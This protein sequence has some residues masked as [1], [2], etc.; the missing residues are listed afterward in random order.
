MFYAVSKI[1]WFLAQPSSLMELAL[2]YGLFRL[3]RSN[4]RHG[5]RW[6]TGGAAALLI[7]GLT[8]LGDLL[9]LPL[10]GRFARAD[11]AAGNIAGIIVLGGAE[12]SRSEGNRELMSLDDAGERMTEGAVLARQL[13][14]ARLVFSGGSDSLVRSKEPEAQAA[15]RLWLAL[16]VDPARLMIEDKSRSTAENATLSKALVQPKP[17]DRW[18]LVTSAWHM[19]RAVGSFRQAGFAVEPWPVDYRASERFHPLKVFSSL[20]EGLRRLDGIAKEYAGL[21]AYWVTG[22]TGDLLPGPV[23]Q[24]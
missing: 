4:G 21:L 22:R 5:R 9:Y 12:D 18:L 13:P 8:P 14:T 23:Q 19:P 17:G 24:N 11:L 3:Y 6:V 10:E 15:K 2:L 20:P 7:G 16:G 1:A